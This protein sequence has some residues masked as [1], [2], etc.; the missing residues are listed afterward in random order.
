MCQSHGHSECT[1]LSEAAADICSMLYSLHDGIDR[2]LKRIKN[3]D[4]LH[5]NRLIKDPIYEKLS[6]KSIKMGPNAN[7]YLENEKSLRWN[8]KVQNFLRH[9][10]TVINTYTDLESKGGNNST[11]KVNHIGM[12]VGTYYTNCKPNNRNN[13]IRLLYA[14]SCMFSTLRNSGKRETVVYH[15][16]GY[17]CILTKLCCNK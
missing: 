6:I 2:L 5:K 1:P 9:K 15:R 7:S 10:Q 17:I 3:V 13:Y 16:L 11:G 8:V 14:R 12:L 4:I